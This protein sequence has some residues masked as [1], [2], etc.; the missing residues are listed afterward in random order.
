MKDVLTRIQS[1]TE[2]DP[3]TGCW[4]YTGKSTAGT[5]VKTIWFEGRAIP[6]HRVAYEQRSGPVPSG[7]L[8]IRTCGNLSCWN[9]E[10][11]LIGSAKERAEYIKENKK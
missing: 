2:E 9:P 5:G 8:V 1:K 11:L 4:N 10:H 7:R 6:V 3:Q